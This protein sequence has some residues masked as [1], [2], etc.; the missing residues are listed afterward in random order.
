[1]QCG[2]VFTSIQRKE[3]Y[4]RPEESTQEPRLVD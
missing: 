4:R 3:W 2:R 1:M